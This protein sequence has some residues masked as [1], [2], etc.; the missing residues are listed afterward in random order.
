MALDR[1]SPLVSGFD[2]MHPN[3]A[4]MYDYW[5]DGKDHF[6]ADREAADAITKAAPTT[7][8][9]VKANRAFLGRVVSYLAREAGID[10]FLDIGTGFP[11]GDNVHQIAQRVNPGARVVY[12]DNDPVVLTHARGVLAGDDHVYVLG[13]DLREPKFLLKDATRWL[14]L[15]RPVGLLLLAIVHFLGEGD[16]DR[17]MGTLIDGLAAG[18]YVA[19]SHVERDEHLVEV[20]GEHYKPANGSVVFRTRD[21]IAGLLGGVELVEPGLVPVHRWRPDP[22]DELRFGTGHLPLLGAVGQVTP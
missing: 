13:A 22:D 14:D 8:V 16:A 1:G 2:P 5:L 21:Q 4:R 15:S 11:T 18:S 17:V 9:M 10:Q 12:C 6:A 19:L 20:A 3:I 7:P